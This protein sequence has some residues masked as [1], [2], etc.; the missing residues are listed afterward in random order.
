M[1]Q[2]A[3]AKEFGLVNRLVPKGQALQGALELAK[4]IAEF[5]QECTR[6]DRKSAYQGFNKREKEAIKAELDRGIHVLVQA[7]EGAKNFTVGNVGRHGS[8]T[9]FEQNAKL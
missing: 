7:R 8:F 1:N 3:E 4:L 9:H 2:G 6:A 5:P